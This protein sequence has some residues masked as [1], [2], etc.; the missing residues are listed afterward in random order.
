MKSRGRFRHFQAQRK[1]DLE[2]TPGTSGQGSGQGGTP[3]PWGRAQPEGVCR[4]GKGEAWEGGLR[5][6]RVLQMKGSALQRRCVW[7]SQS[8]FTS[9]RVFRKDGKGTV[10]RP[11]SMCQPSRMQCDSLTRPEER[12][13]LHGSIMEGSPGMGG[14]RLQ[15]PPPPR[16]QDTTNLAVTLSLRN[17]FPAL[18]LS[19]PTREERIGGR[20]QL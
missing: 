18:G 12:N 1:L 10:C 20:R 11:G 2:D 9:L 8:L 4:T 15:V 3:V 13:V 5:T 14:T 19:P 17:P 7:F 6:E 16:G